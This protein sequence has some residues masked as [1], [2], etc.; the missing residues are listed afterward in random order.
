MTKDS[1]QKGN[2]RDGVMDPKLRATLV[3]L[4][5]KYGRG[6]KLREVINHHPDKDKIRKAIKEGFEFNDKFENE[7]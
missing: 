3:D 4:I 1:R 7:P 5:S 2:E 6:D